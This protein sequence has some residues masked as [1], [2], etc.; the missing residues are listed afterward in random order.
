MAEQ[1]KNLDIVENPKS[2][3]QL[4]ATNDI[5][6][7]VKNYT[8]KLQDKDKA[9]K[10]SQLAPKVL[11]AMQTEW[12]DMKDIRD[13]KIDWN[14]ILVNLLSDFNNKVIKT[15]NIILTPWHWMYNKWVWKFKSLLQNKNL[16]ADLENQKKKGE[17]F[18]NTIENQ[19]TN[20]IENKTVI[21]NQ[22]TNKIENK[23]VI[24]N[25]EN[26]IVKQRAENEKLKKELEGKKGEL[27]T[28]FG[29]KDIDEKAQDD[30]AMAK[31]WQSREQIAQTIQN[32]EWRGWTSLSVSDF[33]NF[34]NVKEEL[35]NNPQAKTN[36]KFTEYS[37]DFE[38]MESS[39]DLP[40]NINISDWKPVP[41]EDLQNLTPE[42]SEQIIENTEGMEDAVGEVE[43]V[44]YANPENIKMDE[45]DDVE[46]D[47]YETTKK[48]SAEPHHK[49]E[50]AMIGRNDP[51]LNKDSAKQL[52]DIHEKI[53]EKD[54]FGG[55]DY[56]TQTPEEQKAMLSKLDPAKLQEFNAFRKK[57][58]AVYSQI[59]TTA[60][61]TA[62][63]VENGEKMITKQLQATAQK[64]AVGQFMKTVAGNLTSWVGD[65]NLWAEVKVHTDKMKLDANGTR[66]TEIEYNGAK[67]QMEVDKN[68]E[69]QMTDL[70][71]NSA[72]LQQK[73]D[74]LDV[75]LAWFGEYISESEKFV[76]DPENIAKLLTESTEQEGSPFGNLQKNIKKRNPK[77]YCRVLG[78]FL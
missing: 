55:E 2:Q 75:K 19:E 53:Q 5:I 39:F 32:S 70:L 26:D 57:R 16:I 59:N 12:V 27:Q 48:L 49:M 54:F 62:Q 7:S 34:L 64:T 28:T 14:N 31:Y 8:D 43:T 63:D 74:W 22:E 18:D 56:F 72:A 78:F 30:L 77:F 58:N 60:H 11:D 61:L 46:S 42:Q 35:K 33:L 51:N 1:M 65:T 71:N 52:H 25:N 36:P 3:E 10:L 29:L 41:A 73:M 45:S 9:N 47:I 66:S 50:L 44:D 67:L 69:M 40:R 23:T 24:E 4:K 21:E 76:S 68:G 37:K 20:K 13:S 6:S 15:Y 38:K 17:E